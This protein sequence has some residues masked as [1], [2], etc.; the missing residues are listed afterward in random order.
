MHIIIIRIVLIRLSDAYTCSLFYN[1]TDLLSSPHS[2]HVLF[3]S[4][5]RNRCNLSIGVAIS[6]TKRYVYV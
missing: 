1:S 6:F 2:A 5:C 4:F 3:S